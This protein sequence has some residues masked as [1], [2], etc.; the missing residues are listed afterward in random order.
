MKARKKGTSCLLNIGLDLS[1]V[2]MELWL[3]SLHI[4]VLE[5]NITVI[6]VQCLHQKRQNGSVFFCYFQRFRIIGYKFS[7]HRILRSF[8]SLRISRTDRKKHF[9]HTHPF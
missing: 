5:Q 7:S 2:V 4:V 8:D 9:T 1:D 3:G 6:T